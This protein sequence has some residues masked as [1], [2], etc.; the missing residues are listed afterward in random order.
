[1]LYDVYR[2]PLNGM[3]THRIFVIWNHPLFYEAIRLSIRNSRVECV[4]A[5]QS[6]HEAY[7]HI[8]ELHP[9]TILVEELEEGDISTGVIELLE[10]SSI[11]VRIFRLNMNNN[12]LK[13][14]HREQKIVLQAD[15]LIQL[16][17]NGV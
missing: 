8:S 14:Y 1:M 3:S 15:D 10:A 17:R 9:D 13:I 11:G 4:G 16:I 5:Y 7:Q 12:E 2:D 6:I